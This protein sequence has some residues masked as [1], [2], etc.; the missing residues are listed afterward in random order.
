M[1]RILFLAALVIMSAVTAVADTAEVPDDAVKVSSAAEL[2]SAINDNAKAYIVL[3]ANID[4]TAQ[5]TITT[6]FSGTIDG[7]SVD[8]KGQMSMFCIF[9]DKKNT[10]HKDPLFQTLD[11]ATIKNVIFSNMRVESESED[12][13]GA[14]CSTMSYCTIEKVNLADI[15]VFADD[16]R[17]GTLAGKATSCHF[18]EVMCGNSDVTVD[19]MYAGGLVGESSG[20]TYIKCLTNELVSVFADGNAL[21]NNAYS[22]GLVGCSTG[23][24]FDYCYN[25][26]LVG[27]NDDRVG[28]LTG[29]SINSNFDHCL[30]SGMVVHCAE[31]VFIEDKDAI[32]ADVAEKIKECRWTWVTGFFTTIGISP[33]SIWVPFIITE[34]FPPLAIVVAVSAFVVGT[35]LT[36]AGLAAGHDEL[37]G[38]C[39]SAKGGT[40]SCC[41]NYGTCMARDN[42]VGGIVGVAE[43]DTEGVRITNCLNRGHVQGS[44]RL[45]G[46]VGI[47][48]S[49]R[50]ENCLN[51]G[52]VKGD[53]EEEV[54]PIFGYQEKSGWNNNYLKSDRYDPTSG[55]RIKVTEEQLAS[56]EVAWWLNQG[57]SGGPWRQNLKETETESKDDFPVLLDDHHLVTSDDLQGRYAIGTAE[58]LISFANTV[59][60]RTKEA[61]TFV[62]YLYNDIDLDPTQNWQPI[63]T[64][65][66]P[67]YGLFFGGGH[68]IDHLKCSVTHRDAGLFGTLGMRTEIHDVILGSHSSVTSTQNAVGG[69]A[70]CVRVPDGNIGSVRIIGCGNQAKVTGSF[71]VAGILGAV[72]FDENMQLVLSDCYNAGLITATSKGEY[73]TTGESAAIC[74]AT[75][76]NALVTRCWNIN[77][78]V[79]STTGLQPYRT[80][81][82][83]VNGTDNITLCYNWDA[84]GTGER[85]QEGVDTFN[86]YDFN[87]GTLCYKLNAEDNNPDHHL[88]WQQNLADMNTPLSFIG[89][90]GE[91]KGVHYTRTLSSTT[92]TIVL[93]YDVASN[94]SVQF[95]VLTGI[96]DGEEKVTFS[97]VDVLKGGTPALF[98][99]TGTGDY[100][101]LGCN[102][103]LATDAFNELCITSRPVTIGDWTMLGSNIEQEFT[104]PADLATL[105]YISGGQVKNATKKLTVG[106]YRSYFTGPDATAGASAPALSIIFGPKPEGITPLSPSLKEETIGIFNTQGQRLNAPQRGLNI[107]RTASGKSV[108]VLLK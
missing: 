57:Q 93:P 53:Y 104:K 95:Y 5:P 14:L 49:S 25:F 76:S 4:M 86:I 30:N 33:L 7:K 21:Y 107:F 103:N 108:K 29:Y 11:N 73:T 85:E 58:E 89:Q 18:T 88:P 81:K 32:M 98:V 43:A 77:N 12:N 70:G 20:C 74:A 72:Y 19:G 92:G 39:G 36:I 83:F 35:V 91:G 106:A 84:Y 9:K 105:Y 26:A 31:E 67:F 100:E 65:S 22:G 40:F 75:K 6:T 78:V 97:P 27:A 79:S 16:N 8:E 10:A 44:Y 52:E 24:T 51:V 64:G 50:V 61:Q 17:A 68:K 69:I 13:R 46:I 71:N 87:N 45:G 66:K 3:T 1:K 102:E 96:D 59:N 28:G 42:G 48:K 90:E 37:G 55:G 99:T 23:D 15:S 56:G 62:A 54:H 47:L 2:V 80:G 63:G 34:S 38:I 82:F 41:S 60:G 94:D 101:F